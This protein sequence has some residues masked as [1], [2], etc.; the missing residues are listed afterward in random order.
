VIDTHVHVV[1]TDTAR[2]PLRPND[3]HATWFRD[4]PCPADELLGLMDAHGVERAVLVQAMGA[5]T[6]DNRY[7]LD[8]TAA[9]P[10]RFAAVVY[11]DAADPAASD[12]LTAAAARGAVGVRIVA[13]TRPGSPGFDAPH[14]R[15]LWAHAAGEGLRVVATTLAPGLAGV[16]PLLEAHLDTPVAID[17]CGFPDLSGGRPFP[18]ARLLFDLARY[19][20]VQVKVSTNALDL[21]V[22]AGAARADLV[23]E[24]ADAY[25][26]ER[27]QWGSNWSHTHDRPYKELV[28][29]GLA[30]LGALGSGA[31]AVVD[32]NARAFWFPDDAAAG[33]A[34]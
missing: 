2:Y 33:F 10:D 29:Q 23:A 16:V 3:P 18:E 31:V 19:P 24:L 27:L 28:A 6:D 20:H 4:H 15:A 13:G 8:A 32:A 14:V 34:G 11:V 26:P 7:C 1:S 30:A 12:A 5:Y 25:G 21:A 9:A 17:H 22:A